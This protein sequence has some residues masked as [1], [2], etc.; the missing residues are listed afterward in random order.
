MKWRPPGRRKRGSK[1][2]WGVGTRGLMGEKGFMVEDWN[3]TGN[4][5]KIM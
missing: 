5:R 4:W 1:L 2:N 3:D